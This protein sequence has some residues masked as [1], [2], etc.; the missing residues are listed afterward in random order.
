MCRPHCVGVGVGCAGVRAAANTAY[1]THHSVSHG[2]KCKFLWQ[3]QYVAQNAIN[4]KK[5]FHDRETGI[6]QEN[7]ESHKKKTSVCVY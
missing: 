1:Y 5:A 4:K 7:L 2:S 3:L 6:E